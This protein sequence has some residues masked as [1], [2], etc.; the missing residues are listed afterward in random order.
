VD[1][2]AGALSEVRASGP[3]AAEILAIAVEGVGWV[4]I[5]RSQKRDVHRI[6]E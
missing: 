4:S 3:E 5:V 1:R 2:G 6:D